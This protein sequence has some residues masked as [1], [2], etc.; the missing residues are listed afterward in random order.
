MKKRI[1]VQAAGCVV[2]FTEAGLYKL[3]LNKTY[4]ACLLVSA[5]CNAVS[6]SVGLLLNLI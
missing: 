5:A 1:T 2:L 3:M 6:F 4:K